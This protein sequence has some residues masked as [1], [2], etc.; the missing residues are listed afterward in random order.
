[1][2]AAVPRRQKRGNSPEP[3]PT[4]SVE[5]RDELGGSAA[6]VEVAESLKFAG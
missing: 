1:M 6:T 4:I 3:A 5:R 2:P